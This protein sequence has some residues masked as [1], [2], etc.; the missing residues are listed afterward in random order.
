[1]P[2]AGSLWWL[3]LVVYLCVD[4]LLTTTFLGFY[5]SGF[6]FS[7]TLVHDK[8]FL[9]G[10]YHFCSSALE[11]FVLAVFRALILITGIFVSLFVAN[12]PSLPLFFTGLSICN[13]SFS[14][15][16]ILA[17][18]EESEQLAF[19]GV[20]LNMIWNCLSFVTLHALWHFVICAN[21]LSLA[22][23]SHQSL[24]SQSSDDAEPLVNNN[25]STEE[26]KETR[27]STLSHV[28]RL[29][30]YCKYHS[31]WFLAGF[32]FLC[33]YSGARVFIPYYTGQVIANM[34]KG[35]ERGVFLQSVFIMSVLT[36]VSTIF[37]GLRGGCFD[38]AT[39]LV[40]RRMR[41]DLFNSI[42]SQEIAFFDS[43]Q[44]GEI[45]SRLT[46][47]CQTM[48]STVS[49]NL[50]VFMR[51]SVMLVGSVIFMINLSW[52]LTLVTLVAVPPIA[53]FSKIYGAYYD[54]LSERTQETIAQANR[55]AEEVIGSV[56]TVRSFACERKECERFD[57]HLGN[58][59][60][61]NQ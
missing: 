41:R 12:V 17:F 11:F 61:V 36:I 26:P 48:S 7:S 57:T 16:K 8:L 6:R 47:D 39:A 23:F 25:E 27:M 31:K 58:T 3:L 46:A 22:E 28:L 55:M 32:V 21:R 33:I 59:L 38:Y 29:L 56:R 44:T 30:T 19:A 34:V 5:Q 2:A 52:R 40:N 1:M 51:N 54:R 53:F 24:S 9:A 60:K 42:M 37:G 15:I 10:G 13:A 20:W 43:S 45:V 50:N 14:L 49:T 35:D 18:S 4:V